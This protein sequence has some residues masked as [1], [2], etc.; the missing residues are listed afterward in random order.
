MCLDWWKSGKY[1]LRSMGLLACLALATTSSAL[2]APG[3]PAARE[4]IDDA[5]LSNE[6]NTADWLAYGRTYSGQRFSPLNQIN[7]SNVKELGVDWY[8]DLPGESGIVSTPLVADGRIYFR[9]SKDFVYAADAVS[10]KRLWTYDPKVGDLMS[11]PA[12]HPEL[13]FVHGGRGVALWQD[14]LY[15]A[16][17]D[18]RLVALDSHSGKPIWSV[19]TLDPSSTQY[20]VGAPIAFHDKVIVGVAG[21]EFGARQGGKTSW[22]RGSVTAY[23][24]KTGKEA[25]RFYVVPGDPAKGFENKAMEMAAKTWPA[26]WWKFGGGGHSWGEGFNYDPELNLLFVS[27]GNPNPAPRKA[28]GAGDSLFTDSVVALDA[29]TG[30]YRWHYQLNPSDQWS[31]D[32]VTPMI[33]ADLR[34]NGQTVK[35]LML[36]PKNGF[37]YVLDRTSGKLISAAPYTRENWASRIDVTTGRPVELPGADYATLGKALVF[38][39]ASG[40]RSWEVMSYNPQTGLVY[41]VSRDQGTVYEPSGPNSWGDRDEGFSYYYMLPSGLPAKGVLQ[42]WDPV[43]QTR[44]WQVDMPAPVSPGTLTT[45]G[46]LVFHGEANGEIVAFDATTGTKLW[47]YALGEGITA[48]PITYSI[49]GRQYVA[50]LT[51]FGSSHTGSDEAKQMGWQYGHQMRQLVVFSLAGK[52]NLPAQPPPKMAAPL[53][54]PSFKVSAALAKKGE[55]LFMQCTLCHGGSLAPDLTASPIPCSKEAF[56]ETLHHGRP[57]LRMPPFKDLTE[58]ELS[59]LQHFIRSQAELGLTKKDATA[60]PRCAVRL[61][62]PPGGLPQGE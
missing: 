52:A 37:F 11:D 40:A 16:T 56:T 22:N 43:K 20:I 44:A 57:S 54:C 53:S 4:S 6:S 18:G 28:R 7:A 34:I 8:I 21:T 5:A 12:R 14:K 60:C 46:N 3:R 39:G 2:Q 23:D 45:A 48:P 41:F 33:R 25:W 30:Q 1:G 42:A 19:Q 51:G 29:D 61:D 24:A 55:P 32:A 13:F 10:G 49:G 36:A 59:A 62:S 27:T 47:H 31:Y 35:A 15:T 58:D 17:V 38:P 9:T 26:G 50:Q